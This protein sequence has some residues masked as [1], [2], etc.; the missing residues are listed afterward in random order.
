MNMNLGW[1]LTVEKLMKLPA[2]AEL[3]AAGHMVKD[4]TIAEA[5]AF[6]VTLPN[7]T[8]MPAVVTLAEDATSSWIV[9]GP[10]AAPTTDEGIRKLPPGHNLSYDLV[11]NRF[12]ISRYYKIAPSSALSSAF[13][14]ANTTISH[15]KNAAIDP[16]S[17]TEP[18]SQPHNSERLYRS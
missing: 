12:K 9:R 6:G 8:S 18:T 17:N 13:R 10:V 11:S 15:V 14:S 7:G 1:S 16:P 5:A 2:W 3:R 4:K